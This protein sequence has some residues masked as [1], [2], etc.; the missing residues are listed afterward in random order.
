MCISCSDLIYQD[1]HICR[2][3][4]IKLDTMF[5]NPPSNNAEEIVAMVRNDNGDE[6]DSKTQSR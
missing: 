6:V 3:V 5:S 1:N 2:N 4:Q